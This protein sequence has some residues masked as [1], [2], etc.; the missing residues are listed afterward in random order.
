MQII[1]GRRLVTPGKAGEQKRKEIE[2]VAQGL[3][4]S[5]Y[6]TLYK[7]MKTYAH[8]HVP[9]ANHAYQVSRWL[10]MRPTR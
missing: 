2:G 10:L 5:L 8:K 3:Q 1:H 6:A 7:S 9:E 4:Y